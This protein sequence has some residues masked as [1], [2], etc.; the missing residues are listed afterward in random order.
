MRL[1]IN[2]TDLSCYTEPK[3]VLIKRHNVYDEFDEGNVKR[4]VGY[5]Y[6]IKTELTGIPD[7]TAASINASMLEPLCEVTFSMPGSSNELTLMFSRPEITLIAVR[8][9]SDGEY[10]DETITMSSEKVYSDDC[11]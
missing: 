9:M 3:H 1:V 2:N 7:E 11:L 6:E 4:A 10:F 5:F 8:S